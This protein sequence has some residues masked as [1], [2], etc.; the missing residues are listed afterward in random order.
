MQDNDPKHTSK[1]AQ[2][3]YREVG[4]NWWRTPASSADINPIKRIWR[5]L[6]FFLARQ[7]KPLTKSDLVEGIQLFWKTVMTADKCITY[8]SHVH[9]VLPLVVSKEGGITGE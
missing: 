7:V 8:I 4:I 2:E 3:F 6:K 5:K 1:K 9:T